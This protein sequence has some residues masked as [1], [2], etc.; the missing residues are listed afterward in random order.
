VTADRSAATDEEFAAR[1]APFDAA[2]AAE[3]SLLIRVMDAIYD[4][5]GTPEALAAWKAHP[6]RIPAHVYARA[7]IDAMRPAPDAPRADAPRSVDLRAY[8]HQCHHAWLAHDDGTDDG[9]HC[10]V[11]EC[12]GYVPLDAAS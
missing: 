4:S 7:A 5:N 8:C 10:R 11:C 1:V 12:D 6:W 3:E 9:D 2:P